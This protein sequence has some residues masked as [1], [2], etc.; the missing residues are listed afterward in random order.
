M[1]LFEMKWLIA[2]LALAT[3]CGGLLLMLSPT[4]KGE[5]FDVYV[6]HEL[7]DFSALAPIDAHTHVFKEDQRFTEFLRQLNMQVLDICVVD[8]HDRGFEDAVLENQVAARIKDGAG[9]R[10][11]WCSTFDPQEFESP[12]FTDQAIEILNDSFARGAVA[13]K[14]YKNIGMELKKKDGSYLMP[15]DPIFNPIFADIA[16]HHGTVYMHL[17]EPTSSWRPLDPEN[18]DYDYYKENSDWYM[19]A[20]P[21][22]PSKETILAARDRLVSNNPNLLFIG[23]HLGSMELDVDEI[24]QRLDKFPNFAIDTAARVVYLAMQPR[25]KVRAFF[26]KYQD[27]ILYGTDNELLPWKDTSQ[28]LRGWKRAYFRDYEYFATDGPVKFM[29]KQY[30]GLGLPQ[31][32]LRKLYHDNVLRWVPGFTAEKSN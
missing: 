6:A 1:K 11:S 31:P 17:A 30:R 21:E 27:R 10:V 9:G 18:P 19:Y 7:S 5:V 25:D 22:R 2:I 28:T 23:C 26:M 32:V 15:D 8:K 3:V 29:G 4:F 24:A 16:A 12:H 13:V 20:H 14:I